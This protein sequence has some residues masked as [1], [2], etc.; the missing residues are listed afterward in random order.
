METSSGCE[1]EQQSMSLQAAVDC[2]RK[3]LM[4]VCQPPDASRIESARSEF[5][6]NGSI[7]FNES[8]AGDGTKDA[9]PDPKD[10]AFGAGVASSITGLLQSLRLE[11]DR[12]RMTDK[13]GIVEIVDSL[14]SGTFVSLALARVRDLRTRNP[15]NTQTPE[16][17]REN[18]RPMDE[19]RP[20]VVEPELKERRQR[21]VLHN[22]AAETAITP[23]GLRVVQDT[24]SRFANG[25]LTDRELHAMR[26]EIAELKELRE[27]TGGRTG[28]ELSKQL[29]RLAEFT[30]DLQGENG[31]DRQKAAKAELS[32]RAMETSRNKVEV[33][34]LAGGA[35]D[36]L[37][38]KDFSL[39][40]GRVASRLAGLL[41]LAALIVNEVSRST[42]DLPPQSR[43][44]LPTPSGGRSRN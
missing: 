11:L 20:P 29:H 9:N 21:G 34:R 8:E 42:S 35:S 6:P 33:G 41:V 32:R 24:L 28:D 36:V 19:Q 38:A 17:S 18:P 23:E 16:G 37:R 40:G 5:V 27:K 3:L 39:E 26:A 2:A 14:A 44:M 1:S 4:D 31:F 22:S 30:A 13:T 7:T 43:P 12:R 25:Q 10:S 15:S